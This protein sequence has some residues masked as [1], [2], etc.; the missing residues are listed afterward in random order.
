MDPQKVNV[1]KN[2]PASKSANETVGNSDDCFESQIPRSSASHQINQSISADDVQSTVPPARLHM[3]RV[4][5]EQPER[6]R[7]QQS[8]PLGLS[9]K[10]LNDRYEV[11]TYLSRGSFGYVYRGRDRRFDRGDDSALVAIKFMQLTPDNRSGFER[12][13]QLM[14][15]FHHPHFVD[16]YDFG[17]DADGLSWL[18]ME[19]LAGRTLD[20]V[21]RQSRGPAERSLVVKFAEQVLPAMNSAHRK[22]LIHRD[23][24]PANIM[25]INDDDPDEIRFKIM[26][27]GT[28]AQ[29]DAT[30][31]LANQTMKSAG[32]PMFMAPEQVSNAVSSPR[33]DLYSI[34]VILF[35]MLSG[36]LPFELKSVPKVLHDVV[37]T[38]P[39]K[40]SSVSP[41]G[42]IPPELDRLI[43]ECL[44]KNPTSRPEDLNVV[45]DR[46]LRCLANPPGRRQFRVHLL[47]TV[48]VVCLIAV[49][50]VFT[51]LMDRNYFTRSVIQP[52]RVIQPGGDRQAE[53]A[54]N[55]GIA[56]NSSVMALGDPDAA[57]ISVSE[58]ELAVPA[59]GQND[60]SSEAGLSSIESARLSHASVAD[61]L[62]VSGMSVFSGFANSVVMVSAA[63]QSAAPIIQ[64]PIV[65]SPV[66]PLGDVALVA[67][68]GGGST[69]ASGL[70]AIE[71]N[72]DAGEPADAMAAENA[73]SVEVNLVQATEEMAGTTAALSESG[74]RPESGMM[75]SNDGVS[76][77]AEVDHSQPATKVDET[78]E[79]SEAERLERERQNA[80]DAARL[81]KSGVELQSVGKHAEAIDVFDTAIRLDAKQPLA[82]VHRGSS[83]LH[84]GQFEA[85]VNDYNEAIQFDPKNAEAL[86][87]RGEALRQLGQ[88]EKALSDL[89]GAIAIDET[90]PGAF[91]SRSLVLL[92]KG[93]L[94]SALADSDKSISLNPKVAEHFNHRGDVHRAMRELDKAIRDYSEA[95]HLD[96]AF[97]TAIVNRGMTWRELGDRKRA[98]A[99]FNAVLFFDPQNKA[100]LKELSATV[101]KKK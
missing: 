90:Q 74:Q 32:T 28:S 48:T 41:K 75:S 94:K 55:A 81:N 70:V 58:V 60:L 77:V 43:A 39:P 67:G 57:A 95:I 14:K 63:S 5:G 100:A 21:M 19:Y 68:E 87:R 24:K 78:P 42:T 99:D 64:S 10:V 26:D 38:S 53:E 40:L 6:Y 65:Q 76:L 29:V 7:R 20:D 83:K 86:A 9:G 59:H 3:P 25:V 61:V 98:L 88:I 17:D 85:A 54:A 44:A 2:E 27:F 101:P 35:Q 46:L 89:N 80:E 71:E 45:R 52:E 30:D 93:D 36:K 49:V 11:T 50:V 47:R 56:E 92:H 1:P 16:V 96:A 66:M 23:L 34:G 82:Y 33:S 62:R 51:N 73:V 97:A 79:V 13:A 72:L 15:R 69:S 4:E 91:H 8:D 18:V 31:T 22:N 84:M 12:E 37:Y